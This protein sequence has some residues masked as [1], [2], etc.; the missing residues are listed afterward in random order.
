MFPY[1]QFERYAWF[2]DAREADQ[3][4]P[5]SDKKI[6]CHTDMHREMLVE[7]Q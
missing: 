6:I 3:A 2:E 1:V 5:L 4:R 7:A